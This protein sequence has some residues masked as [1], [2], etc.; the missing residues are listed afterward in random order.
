[1]YI[2]SIHVVIGVHS[3]MHRNFGN[4]SSVH[5]QSRKSNCTFLTNPSTDTLCSLKIV[6]PPLHQRFAEGVHE[7]SLVWGPPFQPIELD[8]H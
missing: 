5:G 8:V 7:V 2:T 3:K 6:E 1:M 4:P